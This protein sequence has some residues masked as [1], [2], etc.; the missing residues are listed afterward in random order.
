MRT[1]LNPSS[2]AASPFY[3]QGIEVTNPTR[4][5]YV[6]GQVGMDAAGSV[7]DGVGAQ[8]VLAVANVHAVLAEAGL[9]PDAIVK[10]TIF[11]TDPAHVGPFMEAAASSLPV[12]P[13][14][15]TML[16]VQAL[17]SPQLLVEVEAVA[18]A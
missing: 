9:A 2:V 13:P 4:T 1:A 7:P 11:L 6:S 14:A 3:A 15:T 12:D 17:T 8:A 10:V 18:V 16:V 5:I